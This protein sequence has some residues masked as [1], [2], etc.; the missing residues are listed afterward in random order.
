MIREIHGNKN[1]Q[2]KYNHKKIRALSLQIKNMDGDMKSLLTPVPILFIL[3]VFL[4]CS[5]KHYS[6]RWVYAFGSTCETE[7]GLSRLKQI[8]DSAAA[9]GLN[10]FVL[11]GRADRIDKRP[12]EYLRRLKEL[13]VYLKKRNLE[14]IPAIMSFSWGDAL[15]ENDRNLTT[16]LPV[17][18]A[19]FS[20]KNGQAQ[21]ESDYAVEIENGSFEKYDQKEIENWTLSEKAAQ[22]IALI[23]HESAAGKTALRVK[24]EH[25]LPDEYP[26]LTQS[27]KVHPYRLYKVTY[28]INLKKI[29]HNA[30][31][32]FPVQVKGSDGRGL[33]YQI[34]FIP[35]DSAWHK[36]VIAFNSLNYSEVRIIISSPAS[37]EAEYLVDN[38][39]IEEAGLINVL[40][41]PGTPVVVRGADNGFLYEEGKDYD[42]IIDPFRI[43]SSWNE[44]IDFRFDHREPPIKILP[45][46]RIKEGQKLRVSWYHPLYIYGGAF[47]L[48]MS[49]PKVYKLLRRKVELIHE[50]IAPQKYLIS[51]EEI[52][53]GNTCAACKAR[54]ITMAETVGDCVHKCAD[55]LKE[56]NPRVQLYMWGDL[57]DPNHNGDEREGK[58]YFHVHGNYSGSW[59]YIPKD[60]VMIPWWDEIMEKSVQHFDSLGFKTISG[61]YYDRDDDFSILKKMMKD[62]KKY[63]SH[64]GFMYCSWEDKFDLVSAFGDL[65]KQGQP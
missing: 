35:Q 61:C 34:P 3:L 14:L 24:I 38:L 28:W 21:L 26:L 37:Q 50:A 19:L 46:S 53:G 27:I 41:R 42:K 51:I 65:L 17:K 49:E 6:C 63:D 62:L 18:E 5:N 22:N 29:I 25:N 44:K 31:G 23:P 8:A 58:Y 11:P 16:G 13:N 59:N 40:R 47:P 1:L 43:D 15:Y 48:C 7:K 32:V 45:G 4:S 64:T 57:F 9:H 2:G 36:A 30:W 39:S 12:P 56:V 20:V 52:R 55:I 33:H 60:M 10:G 54:N